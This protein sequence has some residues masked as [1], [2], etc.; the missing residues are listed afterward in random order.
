MDTSPGNKTSTFSSPQ[1]KKG[2]TSPELIINQ[3]KYILRSLMVKKHKTKI[4]DKSIGNLQQPITSQPKFP[5]FSLPGIRTCG[6]IRLL[7]GDLPT[8]GSVVYY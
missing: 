5:G 6:R 7:G 8:A 1:Y 2:R 3:P 4:V